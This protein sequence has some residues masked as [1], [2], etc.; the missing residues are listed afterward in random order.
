VQVGL[1]AAHNMSAAAYTAYHHNTASWLKLKSKA[2]FLALT[3][4]I[5]PHEKG[6]FWIKGSFGETVARCK[7]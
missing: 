6:Q 4:Q 3:R 2:V 1:V 5:S 7:V